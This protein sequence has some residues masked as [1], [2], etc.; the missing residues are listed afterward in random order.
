MLKHYH[1][2]GDSAVYDSMVRMAQDFSLRYPLVDG[3]GNFGSIDGD[4]AA[5]YRYTEARLAKLAEEM[6]R[7]IDRET[8]DF[9]PNF[10]GQMDQSRSSCPARFPNLLA[11]GSA[12]IAVGMATNIPPH[13]LRELTAAL[14]V[15]ARRT[16]LHDRRPAREDARAR[17]SR[18]AAM[19]CGTE[20]IR[21]YYAT[22]PR[23]TSPARA[24]EFEETSAAA[25][26]SS[27]R[28][29]TR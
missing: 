24:A 10:D 3:Q 11:N 18:P 8:V 5:A 15:E 16:R 17:T 21:S 22:G 26:S 28:S 7:D 27:P 25:A 14:V 20:G 2:H 29:P 9:Q 19:I 4:S 1:P 6:L 23:A 12:G 13:N